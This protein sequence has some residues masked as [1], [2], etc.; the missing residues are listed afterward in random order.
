MR[1]RRNKNLFATASSLQKGAVI[2][3]A[4]QT[5][6]GKYYVLKITRKGQTLDEWI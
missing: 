6:F 1:L 5:H 2:S 3:L 4:L